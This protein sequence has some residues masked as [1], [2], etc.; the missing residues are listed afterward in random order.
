[1]SFSEKSKILEN[2]DFSTSKSYRYKTKNARNVKFWPKTPMANMKTQVKKIFNFFLGNREKRCN[3]N[4][5]VNSKTCRFKFLIFGGFAAKGH[6]F[7]VPPTL[8]CVFDLFGHSRHFRRNFQIFW[9]KIMLFGI[10]TV[11]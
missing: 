1:M 3:Q 6:T 9:L 2:L 5:V 7:K 10:Q 8:V 4:E 11:L